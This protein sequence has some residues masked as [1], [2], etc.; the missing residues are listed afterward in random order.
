MGQ[1]SRPVNREI[2]KKRTFDFALR[3][4][5]LVSALPNTAM[6]RII[7]SQLGKAGTSV[8]ANY[9]SACRARS[10]AEFIARLGVVEE[11]ADE[12]VFWLELLLAGGIVNQE[13][14][15]GLLQE[16]NDI[17]AMFT[18]GRKSARST[19]DSGKRFPVHRTSAL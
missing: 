3:I 7:A 13:R 9:R 14:L 2:M 17:T 16:A 12:S 5:K 8:G 15:S 10:R 6:G 4:L 1:S 19:T 11:E 18:A